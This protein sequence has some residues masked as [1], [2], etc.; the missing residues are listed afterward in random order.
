MNNNKIWKMLIIIVF[1]VVLILGFYIGYNVFFLDDENILMIDEEREILNNKL[2]EIGSPLGLMILVD[3][4]D[5]WGNVKNFELRK[6][7]NLIEDE[8]NRQ[9]FVMEYILTYQDNYNK[10]IILD[11]IQKNILDDISPTDDDV[12]AY[13]GYDDFNNYYKDLF[14]HDFDIINSKKGGTLYDNKYIYYDNRRSLLNG[15][16]VPMMMVREIKYEN[17]CFV[18]DIDVQYSEM[19]RKILGY[20]SDSAT[21]IYN[22]NSDDNIILKSLIL[23]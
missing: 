17:G 2:S 3:G 18:A 15:L 5:S 6:N 7:I 8:E 10:F 23:N 1:I 16:Y 14:G 4:I 9:L 21:I 20:D 12:L 11:R 13:L 22:R 19:A